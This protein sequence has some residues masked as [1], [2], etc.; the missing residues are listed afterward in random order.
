MSDTSSENETKINKYNEENQDKHLDKSSESPPVIKKKEGWLSKIIQ[1]STEFIMRKL[2]FWEENDKRLGILV[3]FF[4]H[5]LVFTMVAWYIMLHTL[6]PS[7][8][9]FLVFYGTVFFIW[10][11]HIIVGDCV[12]NKIEKK[13]IG[14]DTC[15]VD[16]LME[17]F[18]IPIT[19]E[20]TSGMVILGSS[21][22]FIMLSFELLARTILNVQSWMAF[23]MEK[24]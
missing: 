6:V 11:H 12:L 15:F 13:F 21:L 5:G 10:L 17:A 18:N 3:R 9:L 1:D 14:D 16:Q 8:F 7:Y 23:F 20:S 4:H 2:F 19:P 24:N 22:I